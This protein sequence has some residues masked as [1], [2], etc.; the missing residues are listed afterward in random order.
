VPTVIDPPYVPLAKI[1]LVLLA[2]MYSPA[3]KEPSRLEDNDISCVWLAISEDVRVCA[4]VV[5]CPLNVLKAVEPPEP[6]EPETTRIRASLKDVSFVH[7]VGA[8]VWLKGIRVPEGK[9][10][11]PTGAALS[12]DVPLLVSTF[13][14]VL[15]ATLCTAE[16]PLPSSTAFADSVSVPVPPCPTLSAVVNPAREVISLL[17]PDLA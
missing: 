13:P 1:A 16:T 10:D 11:A 4:P 14:E 8:E 7:P 2:L 6:T 9:L 3:L 5:V 17:A 12:H 15:G